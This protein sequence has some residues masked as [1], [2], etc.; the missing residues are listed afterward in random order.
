MKKLN[1][2]IVALFFTLNSY[3]Q[4]KIDTM[5][6][7]YVHKPIKIYS[8]T[9]SQ[10]SMEFHIATYSYFES[11]KF[12]LIIYGLHKNTYQ[13]FSIVNLEI[14]LTNGKTIKPET[15]KIVDETTSFNLTEKQLEILSKGNINRV[16]LS[17]PF[18]N[19][20]YKLP[21]NITIIPKD[22]KFLSK[23]IGC[24]LFANL[25]RK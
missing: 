13:G 10:G 23:Q 8:K 17:N 3:S 20:N 9:D 14:V 12:G 19:N 7:G 2:I 5:A 21:K 4:C 16:I 22:S 11:Q 24:L 1:I 18:L 6:T 15:A 25:F